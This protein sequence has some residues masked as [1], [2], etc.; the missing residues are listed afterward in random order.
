MSN[1]IT[2][3]RMKLANYRNKKVIAVK[4]EEGYA[5]VI[6]IHVLDNGEA[7]VVYTGD[8]TLAPMVLKKV[9][10]MLEEELENKRDI[11]IADSKKFTVTGEKDNGV[12]NKTTI[13]KED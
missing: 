5:I 1:L 13:M 10:S 2:W 11:I 6:K 12:L 9:K 4:H 8:L 7:R 3:L